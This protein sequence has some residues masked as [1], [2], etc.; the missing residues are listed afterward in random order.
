MP[1]SNYV[2]RQGVGENQPVAAGDRVGAQLWQKP[3]RDWY[4]RRFVRGN[5]EAMDIE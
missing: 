2:S 4:M 3:L 1:S 5:G